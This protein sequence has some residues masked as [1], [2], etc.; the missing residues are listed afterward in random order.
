MTLRD[1]DATLLKI[2][3]ASATLFVD[4]LADA[5]GVRFLCPKCFET[6]KGKVGTHSIVCWFVGVD[7]GKSPNPGRW[8]P[9]GTSLDD[10]SLSGSVSIASPCAAHFHVRNGKIEPA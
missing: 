10:L 9:S 2:L 7:P 5:H 4:D 3:D 1:L 6:H 8:S